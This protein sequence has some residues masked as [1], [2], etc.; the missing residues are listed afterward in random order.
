MSGD[1]V[2]SYG[3]TVLAIER[4]AAS[5]SDGARPRD[6]GRCAGRSSRRGRH[7]PCR[8]NSRPTSYA[9]ASHASRVPSRC[10]GG[11]SGA[12]GA[13]LRR[14]SRSN[15]SNASCIPPMPS[16]MAWWNFQMNP[17]APPRSPSTTV[18]S[19]SG[20]AGSNAVVAFTRATLM[21][22][23]ASPGG[24][25]RRPSAGASRGRPRRYGSS[26][27]WRAAAAG[28]RTTWCMPGDDAARPLDQ[29]P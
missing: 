23:L 20:R 11:R 8:A 21:T 17:A 1:I 14:R 25:C 13:R 24:R 27:A 15:I 7:R 5:T 16:V 2:S 3:S 19:H 29:R 28:P 18:I 12:P 9:T 4:V 10:S 22:A 6:D 26:A